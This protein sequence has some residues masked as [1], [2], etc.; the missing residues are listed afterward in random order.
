MRIGLLLL[1]AMA[2]AAPAFAQIPIPTIPNS[3]PIFG[4]STPAA[5]T[6]PARPAAPRVGVSPTD[7]S[8]AREPIEGL[9]TAIY[10]ACSQGDRTI[11]R[12]RGGEAP[13]RLGAERQMHERGVTDY[14]F[15][16]RVTGCGRAARQHNVEVLAREGQAPVA[17]ALPVGTTAVT[18]IVL[19]GVFTNLFTP[20]V[21]ERYPQCAPRDVR[22]LEANVAQGTPYVAHQSWVENWRF[23][24]CGQSGTLAITFAYDGQGLQ[25]NGEVAPTP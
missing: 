13:I 23:N 6:T 2:F 24:A 14:R 5:P 10:G 20:M 8:L 21:R 3:G 17:M 16:Y 25:M 4:P 19:Q 1:A 9:E 12:V 7:P 18:S 22:I 11:T 15:V